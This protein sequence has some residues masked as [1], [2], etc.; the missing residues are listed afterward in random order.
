MDQ[1]RLVRRV[2]LEKDM[3]KCP[4]DIGR[5]LTV[6]EG[7][8][9]AYVRLLWLVDE[10]PQLVSDHWFPLARVPN[11]FVS[12]AG[13]N[14]I[15]RAL[16]RCGVDHYQRQWSRLS[17]RAATDGEAALLPRAPVL[18]QKALDVDAQGM[19][20]KFGESVWRADR[21]EFVVERHDISE[22]MS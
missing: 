11:I 4:G 10:R 5:H 21:T 9:V 15:T 19:A 2:L 6:S 7:M 20:I 22:S 8:P 1:D 3:V 18:I 17:A 16:K 12:F 14:S 13:L